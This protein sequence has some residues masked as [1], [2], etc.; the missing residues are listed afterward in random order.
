MS[1]SATL[2]PNALKAFGHGLEALIKFGDEVNIEA[3]R[4]QLI[5][6]TV[7]T[8]ITGQAILRM[9]PK[10]FQDY[11][12][13]PP[14]ES[15]TT[16]TSCRLLLKTLRKIIKNNQHRSSAVKQCELKLNGG[17]STTA[18]STSISTGV[19][20]RLHIKFVY[21]NDAEFTQS[22]FTKDMPHS[23]TI[24]PGLLHDYI[25]LMDNR[26][27][28]LSFLFSPTRVII[29]TVWDSSISGQ[30]A[31]RPMQ[32][33]FKISQYDF[34][35]YN[36][37]V[38]T[39]LTVSMKEFKDELTA[40][41]QTAVNY[42]METGDSLQACF[43]ESGKPIVF[44]VEQRGSVIADFAVMTYA[45][46]EGTTQSTGLSMNDSSIAT[47]DTSISLSRPYPSYEQRNHHQQQ[48]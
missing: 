19:E 3:R 8:S 34:A 23:F 40:D 30:V 45:G 9:S 29:K 46:G 6:W 35:T 24:D 44:T 17:R 42:S 11:K 18:R 10:L 32:S 13:K 16:S 47:E 5:L 31:S 27:Q 7:N 37:N 39:M 38:D 41:L 48:Q 26:I 33:Q 2:S 12:I 14:A 22:L 25:T 15:D 1:F 21:E 28:D 43:E 36:V 20:H 4:E